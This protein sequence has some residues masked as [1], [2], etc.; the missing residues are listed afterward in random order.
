MMDKQNGSGTANTRAMVYGAFGNVAWTMDECGFINCASYDPCTGGLIQRI[1]DVQTSGMSGVP[2]NWSTPANG[3]LN[4]VSDYTFDAL[5]RTT[6]ELGPVHTLDLSGTATVVRLVPRDHWIEPAERQAI[7][8]FALQYPLEGYRR[9]TFMMLDRDLVAVSPSTTYR[10]L[11]AAGL[12]RPWNP[13]PSKKHHGDGT[14]T[15]RLQRL[16]RAGVHDREL[17]RARHFVLQLGDALLRLSL[18]QHPR[19]LSGEI[20]VLTLRARKVAQSGPFGKCNVS[21]YIR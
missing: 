3:G 8:D 1:V 20:Q 5:G 4:L 2:A 18:W 12:L 16:R 11:K 7:I 17:Y 19:P 13:K 21:I 14:G 9:L 15:L 6:Q 10:V